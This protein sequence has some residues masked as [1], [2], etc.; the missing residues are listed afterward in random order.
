MRAF[1]KVG[2]LVGF[3]LAIATCSSVV[4][5]QTDCTAGCLL[6]VQYNP[7]YMTPEQQYQERQ[8]EWQQQQDA[9]RDRRRQT[10][11]ELETWRRRNG[12]D[13]PSGSW[14]CRAEADDKAFGYSY[15]YASRS[16]AE[17]RA[18]RE[19]RKRADNPGSCQI[20]SCHE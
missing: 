7:P 13:T 10:E 18:V 11:T 5:A 15:S 19:C 17:A 6:P 16:Q 4:Q 9:D 2:M 1:T 14:G 12:Y 3:A 20:V 8:R